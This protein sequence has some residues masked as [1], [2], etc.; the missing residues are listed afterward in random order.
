M[1]EN[2]YVFDAARQIAA[3]L[4]SAEGVKT[5]AIRFPTDDEWIERQRKRKVVIKQLGRGKSET[6]VPPGSEEVD[7]E[8]VAR[9]R[10]GAGGPEIDAFEASRILE[11]ISRA[12]VDDVIPE[13]GAFRILLRVPGGTTAHVLAMPSAKDIIQYRR[14]FARVLDGP[15][16]Q[17]ELT[18]NLGATAELYKRLSQKA[19]GYYAGAVPIIHQAAVVKAAI[20]A[21]ETG[22]GVAEPENF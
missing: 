13:G 21:L 17:Q 12:D 19:E 8:F 15:F 14:A 5:I 2:G 16:N 4:R 6:I 10:D 18:I 1:S 9:L 11:D 7:A 3:K 22:L 20:D